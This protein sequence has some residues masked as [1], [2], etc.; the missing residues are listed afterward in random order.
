M[1]R[2]KD[3]RYGLF[4][5]YVFGITP[6]PDLTL[7]DTWEELTEN[8]DAEA[9]ADAAAKMKVDYVVFTAWHFRMRPLYPS[10]VTESLRPGCSSKRDLLGDVIDALKKR[11]IETILYTH[12][13][14]GHDLVGKDREVTGWGE[15]SEKGRED[16]PK[17][18]DFDFKKWNAYVQ[19]L[20]SELAE[21]YGGRIAGFYTDGV[22]PTRGRSPGMEENFQIV[23]YTAL[24]RVMKASDPD[25]AMIQNYFGY[26]FSDD[27]A[28]PEGFFGYESEIGFDPY[29]LPAPSDSIALCPFVGWWP[30]EKNAVRM[31]PE[32]MALYTLFAASS[33]R[34]GGVCWAN[35]PFSGGREWPKD[36]AETLFETGEIL[37]KYREILDS[38]RP[39]GWRPTLPGETIEKL[40]GVFLVGGEEREILFVTDK[41][42]E[43]IVLP[44]PEDG[45]EISDP[46]PLTDGVS[47]R[48]FSRTEDG[49]VISV[50]GT[51]LRAVA[52]RK[53][54]G[55]TSCEWINDA[56]KRLRFEGG[57][58]YVHLKKEDL[59]P[60]GCY[61]SDYH[62]AEEK[63]A[64][65]F[66]F[67]E[68]DFIQIF[69]AP[70][71]D[72]AMAK[73]F[74]DGV[75]VGEFTSGKAPALTPSFSGERLF[76]GTHTLYIV[77][78]DDRPFKL[79]A[80]KILL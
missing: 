8:F 68:G 61:D 32:D 45:S 10:K 22:G 35:S 13:R 25:M 39:S 2:F 54:G 46:E 59:S 3:S 65:V 5:H 73:V 38:A 52:F 14:D 70:A 31:A 58:K 33:S 57:W 16:T 75:D 50:S 55:K 40:G 7:P 67:F 6:R 76:G 4:V 37:E 77:S 53:T 43:K 19:G 78:I 34:A 42:P 71:E 49:F 56:D 28:M 72:G 62:A 24:R 44:I 30:H 17:K 63:G 15:G 60:L 48:E 80:I 27:F 29:R 23:D 66:T 20:Y 79:D 1:K 47:V 11:G 9:F 21:R 36:S 26:I 51:G 74:I 41:A 18:E 12:P 69:T 64:S